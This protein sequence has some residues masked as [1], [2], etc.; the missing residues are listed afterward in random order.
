MTKLTE[1]VT[2]ALKLLDTVLGEEGSYSHAVT[3][4]EPGAF[5]YGF[6]ARG[7]LTIAKNGA[8]RDYADCDPKAYTAAKH[9]KFASLDAWFTKQ[10]QTIRAVQAA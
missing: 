6:Y 3:E 2:A 8:V 9:S 10:V 7:V 4:I 5:A 1:R